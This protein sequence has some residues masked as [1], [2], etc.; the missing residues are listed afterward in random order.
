MQL[1]VL[2]NWT[3]G[4]ESQFESNW[5]RARIFNA[6]NREYKDLL[7]L[8]PKKVLW[9][10][11]DYHEQHLKYHDFNAITSDEEKLFSWLNGKT[12]L[13]VRMN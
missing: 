2:I 10:A 4:H 7:S 9:D 3:D 8:G 13:A 5:L 11:N 12:R 1:Q 6:V